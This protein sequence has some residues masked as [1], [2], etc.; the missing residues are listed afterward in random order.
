MKTKI[1]KSLDPWFVNKTDKRFIASKP[2]T[3][4]GS[5]FFKEVVFSHSKTTIFASKSEEE[6]LTINLSIKE[7]S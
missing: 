1:K 2:F 6:Q 5:F 7:K 4:V 3:C